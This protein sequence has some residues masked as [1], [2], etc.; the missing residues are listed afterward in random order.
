MSVVDLMSDDDTVVGDT[1]VQLDIVELFSD[2]DI[3]GVDDTVGDAVLE[4]HRFTVTGP[5]TPMPRPRFYRGVAVNKAD[6]R[7]VAFRNSARMDLQ[8]QGVSNFPV[9]GEVP[10][11][12]EIWFC[13]RLPNTAFVNGDR[14][15]LRGGRATAGVCHY[16][17]IKPDVD[18]FLKFVL[19]GL[20]GVAF[21]DDKWVVGVTCYKCDDT[22][23]P[24]TGKTMCLL[25]SATQGVMKPIPDWSTL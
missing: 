13:M 19:D 24:Y 1:G 18:N 10:V 20:K 22:T 3:V 14:Q 6:K 9:M 7:I 21:P 16:R 5:P 23:P 17:P 2:D 4:E 15:R 8:R 11:V 25:K 12:L